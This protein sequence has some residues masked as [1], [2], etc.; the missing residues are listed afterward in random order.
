MQATYVQEG[1][2]IDYTPTSA[3]A[4]GQVV[5]LGNTVG[6]ASEPIAASALGALAAEGLFDVAKATGAIT[7]GNAVYWDAD[8]DPVGGTAGTGAA[9]TTATS[10]TYMGLA[11]A[12]AAETAGTVRVRLSD[13]PALTVHNQYTNVV[14][15]PGA[16]GAI[17]VTQSGHVDL[18]TAGAETR[19]LAAPSAAGQVLALGF[20]TKVGNCVITCATGLNGTGNNTATFDTAG[21]LLTLVALY[22]GTNLRWRVM[23]NDG[24]TLSTV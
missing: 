24:V 12:D 17:P 10:N 5:V 16:S 13:V 3:V 1:D 4:A 7:A 19:T 15:D 9:T 6:I 11:V 8:G 20:K 21:D 14:A 18:V 23:A 2:M 22:V